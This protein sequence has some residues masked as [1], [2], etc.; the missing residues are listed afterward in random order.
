MIRLSKARLSGLHLD[1]IVSIYRTRGN[2]KAFAA[3][4]EGVIMSKA[5]VILGGDCNVRI[6]HHGAAV[7]DV[8]RPNC[9]PV[10]NPDEVTLARFLQHANLRLL[11]GQ[12]H[13]DLSGQIT[14][15]SF[16]SIKVG[17]TKKASTIDYVCVRGKSVQS[18][19]VWQPPSSF[20][21][22]HSAL[23][24]FIEK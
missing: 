14:R 9:D 11:N 10:S 16:P 24:V 12:V 2:V 3:K 17:Q 1:T 22:D 18:M 23:A 4:L 13:G 15:R 19:L 8:H 7:A 21:V 5:R 20:K 6:G